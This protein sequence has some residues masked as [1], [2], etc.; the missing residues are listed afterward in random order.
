MHLIPLNVLHTVVRLEWR[1]FHDDLGNIW[2][3]FSGDI[4]CWTNFTF[5][6]GIIH[7]FVHTVPFFII[8]PDV[9]SG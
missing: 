2:P 5:G 3:A 4:F 9:F 7:I 1:C 8:I 6:R